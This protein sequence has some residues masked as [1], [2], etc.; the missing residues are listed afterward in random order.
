VL[1]EW[2]TVIIVCSFSY[3]FYVV[4]VVLT[5]FVFLRLTMVLSG[6]Q[7][8]VITVLQEMPSGLWI[9]ALAYLIL[10]LGWVILCILHHYAYQLLGPLI[11][12]PKTFVAMIIV[13]TAA[14]FTLC[15]LDERFVGPR[16]DFCDYVFGKSICSCFIE[17]R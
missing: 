10:L 5:T 3:E 4:L 14:Q 2:R 11:S 16:R 13:M 8:W 7:F 17:K 6:V 9:N 12:W 1:L 15:Q